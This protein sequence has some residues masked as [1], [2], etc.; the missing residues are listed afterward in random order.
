M[1]VRWTKTISVLLLTALLLSAL[2]L[3]GCGEKEMF[4]VSQEEDGS[5]SVTAVKASAGS[6][7]ISYLTVGEG[8]RIVADSSLDENG[9]IRVELLGTVPGIDDDPTELLTEAAVGAFTI[10]G[11]GRTEFE[12]APGEY[13]LRVSVLER[14]GGSVSIGVEAAG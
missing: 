3:G 6:V 2:L 7:G 5:V 10:T 11:P 1:N 14:A 8:E 4:N 13:T 9:S 12:A